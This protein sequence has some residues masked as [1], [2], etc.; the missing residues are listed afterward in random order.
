M[1]TSSARL[2]FASR[3]LLRVTR[4]TVEYKPSKLPP[5]SRGTTRLHMN[6]VAVERRD[7]GIDD[8]EVGDLLHEGQARNL[9]DEPRVVRDVAHAGRVERGDDSEVVSVDVS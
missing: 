1:T 6:L 5:C 2:G 7:L 4:S 3:P 9:R 8:R